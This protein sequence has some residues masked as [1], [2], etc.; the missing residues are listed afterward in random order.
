MSLQTPSLQSLMQD[1]TMPDRTIA[2]LLGDR[3]MIHCGPEA[4]LREVATILARA[5]LGAL[6]ITEGDRL[7][8]IVSERDIVFRAVAKGLDLDTTPARAV[9]TE[10]PVTVALDAP[11]VDTLHAHL[12]EDFRHLPVLDGD[13]PVGLLSYRDI[14]QEYQMMFERFRE[15]TGATADSR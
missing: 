15:M 6:L 3:P 7:L 13:R 2:A 11:I 5:G 9:M 4:S 8:G 1:L 10:N 14:P 12:G